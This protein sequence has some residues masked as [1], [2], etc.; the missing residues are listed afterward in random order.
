MNRFL[1]YITI[2]FTSSIFICTQISAEERPQRSKK[3]PNIAINI[4]EHKKIPH[5]TYLNLGLLSNFNYLNGMGINVISSITLWNT[6]GLQVA[7][8]ANVTGMNVK[9]FQISGIANVTGR[10]TYGISASGLMN[11]NGKDSYGML[12]SGLGNISGDTSNGL[13]IS[14]LINMSGESS[15]GVMLS[16]LANISGKEQRGV[17]LSGLANVSATSLQGVQISSLLN[18]A[19][20]S[21]KGLQLAA[22]G[23]VSV[24]NNG[25]QTALFNY[26]AK[27]NGLQTGLV[28]I[29]S[30][31]GRGVQLGIANV[32]KN[33]NARQVG[34]FNIRPYTRTQ[35]IISG[36][37]TS[38][39]NISIRL[40]NKYTYTQTGFGAYYLDFSQK[41]S[42]T[43]FYRI[44]VYRTLLP[45]LEL[46]ADMGYYHIETFKN[47]DRGYAARMYALQPKIN[48]EYCI[49]EKVGIFASGG[50]NWTRYYGHSGNF[51]HKVSFEVGLVLF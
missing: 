22:L 21:N 41:F 17:L 46:S 31:N 36:G 27:N 39:L 25:L 7:G 30:E 47:K 43:G 35:L 32:S 2:V 29:N 45:K 1:K 38:K 44:G 18:V 28:N 12:I 26:A 8:I 42:A 33:E 3:T 24:T 4:S 20:E 49:T 51:D 9:G 34:L 5:R 19:G 10:N 13:M 6:T 23:N 16:G 14:G 37:N 15:N 50:Y 40:K 11:I 48:L